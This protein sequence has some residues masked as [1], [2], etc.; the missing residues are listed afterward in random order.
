MR[1]VSSSSSFPVLVIAVALAALIAPA[2][3]GL[4]GATDENDWEKVAGGKREFDAASIKP[5]LPDAQPRANFGLNI[6]NEPLPPGGLLG[7]AARSWR[8]RWDFEVIGPRDTRR[9]S[10]ASPAPI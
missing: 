7:G 10:L 8:E 6:D 2:V 1:T 9:A 5:S 4:G 3:L